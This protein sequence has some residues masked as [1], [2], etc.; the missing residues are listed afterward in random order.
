MVQGMKDTGRMIYS[1]D[2]ER[3]SGQIILGTKE[4][5]M[6]E[7]STVEDAMF[8]LMVANTMEIGS[9]IGLKDMEHT[10]GLMEGSILDP[11]KTIIC[12]VTDYTLGKMV[13]D[14]RDIMKWTKSMGLECTSGQME[15]DM[16]V[17]G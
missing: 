15:E 8:G 6:K 16:R 13:E 2:L 17:I 1:M 12:M 4:S 5:I 14:T 9:K 3:K 7:K 11:G 10:L